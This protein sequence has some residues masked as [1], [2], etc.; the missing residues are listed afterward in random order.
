MFHS[1]MWAVRL[2][3]RNAS[4]AARHVNSGGHSG[5]GIVEWPAMWKI[6]GRRPSQHPVKRIGLTGS[7][8]I[9]LYESVIFGS[10]A[11]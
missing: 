2:S 7:P 6:A 11:N 5:S 4:V 9:C 8:V 3:A 1:K 10:A